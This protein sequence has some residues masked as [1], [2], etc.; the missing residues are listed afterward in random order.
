VKHFQRSL[1]TRVPYTVFR[2][3]QTEKDLFEKNHLKEKKFSEI[4]FF[5]PTEASKYEILKLSWGLC[6]SRSIVSCLMVRM[7]FAEK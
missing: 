6:V 3:E 2:Y 7:C 4:S 1:C 5:M